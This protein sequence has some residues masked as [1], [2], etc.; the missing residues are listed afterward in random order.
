MAVDRETL[1]EWLAEKAQD[2]RAPRSVAAIKLLLEEQRRDA[3]SDD[4]GSAFDDLDN[5]SPI[6]RPA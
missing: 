2:E 1:L 5:V 4:A 6:R 3:S